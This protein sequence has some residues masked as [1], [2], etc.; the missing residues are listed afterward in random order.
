MRWTPQSELLQQTSYPSGNHLNKNGTGISDRNPVT[1]KWNNFF[2]SS[3]TYSSYGLEHFYY[4]PTFTQ[5]TL[6]F[7]VSDLDLTTTNTPILHEFITTNTSTSQY[8]SQLFLNNS[9]FICIFY[10]FITR[11]LIPLRQKPAAFPAAS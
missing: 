4:P 10:A 5:P 3:S 11:M 7:S 8:F 6:T 1:I 2:P 9:V